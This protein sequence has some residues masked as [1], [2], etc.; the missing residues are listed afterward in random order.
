L[1]SPESQQSGLLTDSVVV[2]DNL[3]TVLVNE[4]DRVIGTLPMVHV[5]RALR[6]TLGL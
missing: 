3:A 2:T 1:S 6:H 5:D 4:I